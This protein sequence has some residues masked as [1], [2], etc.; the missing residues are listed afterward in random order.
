MICDIENNSCCSPLHGSFDLK[1]KIFR[2]LKKTQQNFVL[3][4]IIWIIG[5]LILLILFQTNFVLTSQIP[6]FFVKKNKSLQ[7][8]NNLSG[9]LV[10][11]ARDVFN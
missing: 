6:I 5:Q 10:G 2:Q 1:N 8:E 11:G 7:Q 9:S 3:D 4:V